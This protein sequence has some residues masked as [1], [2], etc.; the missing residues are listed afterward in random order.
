MNKHFVGFES[1]SALLSY[2]ASG[3]TAAMQPRWIWYQAPLDTNA[4][5]V[6]VVRVYKNGKVRLD[7]CSAFADQFTADP[8]HLDRFRRVV[9][10]VDA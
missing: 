6:R 1:W 4:R 10:S 3:E 7:P 8:D 2:L 5:L 9:T